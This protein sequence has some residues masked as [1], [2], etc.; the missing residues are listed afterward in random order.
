MEQVTYKWTGAENEDFSRFYLITE[1]YYDSLVG[2]KRN[3][4]GF[5]PY[6]LSDSIQYVLIAYINDNAAACAGLKRYSDTDAEIKRVWVDPK[7]RGRH[8]A[9]EMMNILEERAALLGFDRTVLQTREIMTAAVSLYKERGYY[10]IENY[11]P[12][13][14]LEGA[15]CF[16]KD[17]TR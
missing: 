8:I 2:G 12:Y 10:Q 13:D 9:T 4:S 7:Y 6:N 17:L 3:R 16:A 15:V 14:S 5:V 11:P 1:E